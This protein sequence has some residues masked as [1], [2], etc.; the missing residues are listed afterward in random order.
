M[1]DEPDELDCLQEA[2]RITA[3]LLDSN[4]LKQEDARGRR[5]LA[6]EQVNALKQE[7]ACRI[8]SWVP[9]RTIVQAVKRVMADRGVS[10]TSASDTDSRWRNLPSFAE[11]LEFFGTRSGERAMA[12]EFHAWGKDIQEDAERVWPGIAKMVVAEHARTLF[13]TLNR[14]PPQSRYPEQKP[15]GIEQ[16]LYLALYSRFQEGLVCAPHQ[17]CLKLRQTVSQISDFLRYQRH[18]P[19][20]RDGDV[21]YEID[22]F[23]YVGFNIKLPNG[24]RRYSPYFAGIECDGHE[25][26]EK[27]KEQATKDREKFRSLKARGLDIIPF[28]GSEITHNIDGCVGAIW[29]LLAAHARERRRLLIHGE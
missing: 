18:D 12:S 13:E 22:L 8:G 20:F 3:S 4:W 24:E 5:V 15:S 28:T 27:T 16:K 10:I 25:F 17:T 19:V 1:W 21:N 11:T 23:L 6:T 14:S 2:C 26:H 29:D 9:F 7:V